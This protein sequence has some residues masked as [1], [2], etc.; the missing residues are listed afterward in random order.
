MPD[1]LQPSPEQSTH[2]DNQAPPQ[3][4]PLDSIQA[5]P[6]NTEELTGVS[7][8]N[9]FAALSYLTVLVFV[10]LLTRK[11]DPYVNFHVRQ[12]LVMLVAL[13]LAAIASVWINVVGATLF[14]LLLIAD[15]VAL[16]MTLQGRRWRIPGIGH[17]A[18]KI[19]I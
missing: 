14:L 3:E 1:E 17:L 2:P 13:I 7:E 4:S 5:P 12:G 10:P 18:E 15:I 6:E 11:E 16:V 9:L 8:Q 19:S